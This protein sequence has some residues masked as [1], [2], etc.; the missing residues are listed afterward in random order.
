MSWGYYDEYREYVPV[1]QKKAQ[2]QQYARR[3]AKREGRELSPVSI[4]GTKIAKTFWGKAWCDHL[5]S[6]SDFANRLPR[7]YVVA[8]KG[9]KNQRATQASRR[10]PRNARGQGLCG[11]AAARLWGAEQRSGAGLLVCA[12]GH[13][14][15]S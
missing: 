7:G 14:Q 2:A 8:R 13:T 15:A 3:I 11:P 5:A 6:F 9:H 1:A 12:E 4:E 10:I